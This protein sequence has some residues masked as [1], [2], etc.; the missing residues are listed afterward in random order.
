MITLRIPVVAY[1]FIGSIGTVFNPV[2]D[3]TKTHTSRSFPTFEIIFAYTR[4]VFSSVEVAKSWSQSTV[5]PAAIEFI[6]VP[7]VI[8]CYVFIEINYRNYYVRFKQVYTG[9]FYF[10]NNCVF[11]LARHHNPLVRHITKNWVNR[12]T[13]FETDTEIQTSCKYRG[14]NTNCHCCCTNHWHFLRHSY[15]LYCNSCIHHR[16]L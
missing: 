14:Y 6:F 4:L 12:R 1:T 7:P 13:F 10:T 5:C 3:C 2:T 9:F 11:L 8:R 16:L 15:L